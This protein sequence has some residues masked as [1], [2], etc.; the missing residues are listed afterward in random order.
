MAKVETALVAV[1]VPVDLLAQVDAAGGKRTDVMLAALRA[2]LD[3]AS[4]MVASDPGA[5]AA[6]Q[7]QVAKLKADLRVWKSVTS[8]VV[9]RDMFG[10]GADASNAKPVAAAL[11]VTGTQF[12]RQLTWAQKQAADAARKKPGKDGR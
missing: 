2:H 1:R 4:V 6:C 12:P 8:Q 5:L 7:A 9:H 11:P 3:P 10:V